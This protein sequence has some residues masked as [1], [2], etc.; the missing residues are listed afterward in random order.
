MRHF[1]A[2]A[3]ALIDGQI[4]RLPFMILS[5][6]YDETRLSTKIKN[7]CGFAS[8][9]QTEL[10]IGIVL[11]NAIGE[12]FVVRAPVHTSLKAMVDG[13]AETVKTTI[14]HLCEG[15]MD[16]FSLA[17]RK[18]MLVCTDAASSNLEWLVL[19][20]SADVASMLR[21]LAKT[22]FRLRFRVS[23]M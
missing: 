23:A 20:S 5:K 6:Q 7:W 8:I 4:D 12:S 16:V 2:V 9:M 14:D 1:R 15:I 17:S 22:K 18:A 11:R 21:E 3:T 19:N 10:E 13:T